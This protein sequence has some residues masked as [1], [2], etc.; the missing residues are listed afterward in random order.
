M[1]AN[2]L[3]DDLPAVDESLSEQEYERLATILDG[4]SD[5]GAM[6]IE[7]M[8]G[9]FAAL[10]CSPD[11]NPPSVFLNEM[12]GDD[13][14]P[15]ESPKEFADFVNLALRH[16]NAVSRALED[17][18]EVFL[19]WLEIQEGEEY[20]RGNDWANGF[21]RGMALSRDC[22]DELAEDE[23]KMGLLIPVMAFAHENDPDPELRPWQTPPDREKRVE[24]LGTLAAVTQMLYDHFRSDRMREARKQGFG[25]RAARPKIGRNDPCYCGSGKKYK[26]CCGSVTVN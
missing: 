23:D 18:K 21:L 8:D 5:E 26:R 13:D 19:P 3:S 9:F 14:P 6:D 16:W 10:L 15:F 11:L 22:W 1:S 20:P 25:A 7:E 24:L 2:R 17:P 4:L 12:W